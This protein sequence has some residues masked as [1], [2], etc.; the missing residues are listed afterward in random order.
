MDEETAEAAVGLKFQ[1][2]GVNCQ[3]LGAL[4][5]LTLASDRPKT[6]FIGVNGPRVMQFHSGYYKPE[7]A[8]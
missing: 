6:S 5:G 7:R 3:Q 8:T 1:A 2:V 4:S